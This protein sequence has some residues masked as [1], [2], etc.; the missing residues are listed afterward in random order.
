MYPGIVQ[1]CQKK[2]ASLKIY[3]IAALA[4][5]CSLTSNF[6]ITVI[7]MK[8]KK[9]PLYSAHIHDCS[10]HTILGHR[11]I[12]FR[13]AHFR[14]ESHFLYPPQTK[15]GGCIVILLSIRWFVRPSQSLIRYSSKTAEHRIS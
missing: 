9:K 4:Q 2:K 10:I 8:S 5:S 15:L 11:A 13:Q 14:S 3:I 12:K 7:T 1:V 6:M